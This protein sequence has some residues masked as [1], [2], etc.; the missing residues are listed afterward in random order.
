MLNLLNNYIIII[1]VVVKLV[2]D[3]SEAFEANVFTNIAFSNEFTM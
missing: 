1:I 3:Q 2:K